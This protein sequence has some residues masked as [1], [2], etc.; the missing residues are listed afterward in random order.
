MKKFALLLVLVVLGLQSCKKQELDET[1]PQQLR[2]EVTMDQLIKAH[3]LEHAHNS[4]CDADL[5]WK[6][7]FIGKEAV[8]YQVTPAGTILLEG[9]IVVPADMITEQPA[10][11]ER[12]A[13]KAGVYLWPQAKVYYSFVSGYPTNLRNAFLTACQVWNYYTGVQFIQRTNQ[14]N[15]IRVFKDGNSNYSNLGFLGG[16]QNLSLADSNPGVAIHELAHA[17]GLIHE[18]Q[19]SDRN[20]SIWV[21]PALA[22]TANFARYTNSYNYSAF[23]WNSIMLY[24]S[25]PYGTSWTMLTLPSYVPFV[26]SIEYWRAN[27]TYALPSNN[28]IAAINYLY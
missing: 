23:D 9:D 2:P 22:S 5:P 14:A 7:G 4:L 26:N 27:G 12:S 1:T 10:T 17:L 13:S 19:R 28:D 3:D 6:S 18:H 15:Y 25:S 11:E 16:M 8:Q 21:N 24:G 20:S